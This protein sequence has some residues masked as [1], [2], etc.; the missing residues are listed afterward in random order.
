MVNYGE[1][2]ALISMRFRYR[3][4]IIEKALTPYNYW[5]TLYCRFSRGRVNAKRQKQ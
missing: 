3:F 2:L 4:A 1:T 5:L